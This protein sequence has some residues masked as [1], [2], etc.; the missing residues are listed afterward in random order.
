[1]HTSTHLCIYLSLSK[2]LM[3]PS[4]D[5]TFFSTH[6]IKKK[7]C[8]RV[9]TKSSAD[10]SSHIVGN[11]I[12]KDGSERQEACQL[13]S[14]SGLSWDAQETPGSLLLSQNCSGI[15][16]DNQELKWTSLGW[17]KNILMAAWERRNTSLF[18]LPPSI[19][20]ES[21]I[22]FWAKAVSSCPW[23]LKNLQNSL[24]VESP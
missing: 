11:V 22:W 18:P 14:A 24:G 13:P 4:K 2:Q 7:N 9:V 23:F 3:Q 8:Q 17:V 20:Q 16:E 15:W 10:C 6:P 21:D 19:Y 12:Q 5:P 1:M